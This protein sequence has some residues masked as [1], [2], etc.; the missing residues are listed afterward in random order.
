[1]NPITHFLAS[2]TVANVAELD[3]RERAA[4]TLAGIVPDIDGF[5]L[6]AERLTTDSNH[7]ITWWSD[8]HHVL[9]HNLFF[10]LIITAVC[11]SVAT[12]KWTVAALALLSFHVHL[13][14]DVIGAG[15]PDG[16]HWP[17]PYLWPFTERVQLVWQ[18]QWAINAWQ[19]VAIT[20]L[21]LVVTFVLAW[22]RG[23]SP[24]EMISNKADIAFVRT[25]K[26]RFKT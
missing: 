26:E 10:G 4:V 21:L 13:L 9:A 8:Y 3:K 19:N 2:W 14:G 25:L 20:G 22:R 15:G 17:I 11:I 6:F 7:P 1:M 24:L 16:E 5:G 12:R 23:Y 18:G